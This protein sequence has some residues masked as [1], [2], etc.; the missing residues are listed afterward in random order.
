MSI[1]HRFEDAQDYLDWEV[2]IATAQ[3]NALLQRDDALV[4]RWWSLKLK[5][6]TLLALVE[7]FLALVTRHRVF[8]HGANALA[9][10]KNDF[11]VYFLSKLLFQK[12]KK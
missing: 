6:P 8:F 11:S 9:L 10:V 5:L 12:E 2:D 3:R 7:F 1:L 4:T